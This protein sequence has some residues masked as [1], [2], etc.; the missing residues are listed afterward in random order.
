MADNNYDELDR[1]LNAALARYAA[2]EPRPGL[3]ERVLANLRTAPAAASVRAW[4]RWSLAA[5]AVAVVVVALALA[6]R[7]GKP[8]PVIANHPA[9][10]LDNQQKPVTQVAAKVQPNGPRPQAR[11]RSH[12]NYLVHAPTVTA[13]VPKLDQFPSP[14]PLSEQEKILADYVRQFHDQAVQIA[15]VTNAEVQR[16][17]I[18]V[19]GTAQAPAGSTEHNE[20]RDR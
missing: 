11:H 3:E 10:A 9:S 7:P 5:A 15:R 14:Q 16:D 12:A 4:W 13:A 1:Q 8:R 6:L 2:V 20:T 19:I 18:E 17:R